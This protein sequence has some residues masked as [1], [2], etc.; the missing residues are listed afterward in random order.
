MTTREQVTIQRQRLQVAGQVQGVGFRPFVYRLAQEVHLPGWVINDS[1]GVT[2]ELQGTAGQLEEF[3]RR[4][5]AELPP[6][7]TISR[8]DVRDVPPEDGVSE[9]IIKPSEGGELADAQ[10]T[11][12]T[13]VCDDCLREMNDPAD[14]RYHSPFINCTNCGPRYTIVRRIPYDRPNTTMA[15]FEMCPLCSREY[16]DPACRRFHAQPIACPVCGPKVW[17]T[18]AR[19]VRVE[20]EDVIAR[21]AELLLDG[22]VLAIKGLG[23]FHLACR[24]DEDHVVRAL[25]RR[26]RRDAKPFAVMVADL[27]HVKDYCA[28]PVQA[29]RLLEGITRPIVLLPM[30][31]PTSI[32]PSVADGLGTLGIML[33]YTPL[34]HLL[35]G[36][37]GMRA[38]P[39]VMTSGNYSD[40]PLVKD[41]DA[42]IAHLGQI[43]DFLLMH[44][45]PIERRV[46][47]SV[48][49]MHIDGSGMLLRRGRGYA[50]KPV[51]LSVTAKPTEPGVTAKPEGATA[52]PSFGAAVQAAKNQSSRPAAVLGVGP[53]LK[54]TVCLYS[55]G[56]A[57]VSEHIG[58]LKDG[59]VYRHFIDT[60]NHL[61]DLFDVE[62]TV[63]AADLH[64]QYLSTQYAMR[65]HRGELEGL[66]GLPIIRVQHHHAHIAAC[67]AEHGR[68]DAV[69]G[70]ACDGVGLGDD[71]AVWGCEVML[72]DLRSYRRLGH[73]RY[74][75]LP[76]G[77]AAAK[78]TAR[79]A[80]AAMW[81]TF[82]PAIIEM[83]VARHLAGGDGPLERAIEMLST[84][85]NCPPS[86]SLGRWFDAVAALS[87]VATTNGFEGQAPMRLEAAIVAGAENAYTFKLIQPPQQGTIVLS[88]GPVL[89]ASEPPFL[90]DLRP[91]VEEIVNELSA[92]YNAGIIAARFHNTVAAF[93]LA[94]AVKA[95]ELTGLRTVALSG[96]C[97]AN[98]YLTHRLGGM[99]AG[100]GFEVL[101]HINMPCNDGCVSLGQAV[102]A[103]N[104]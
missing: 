19:G 26:K 46:D 82:G 101:H 104:Q 22:K 77:D 93:L 8:L 89:K 1:R 40:E 37:P 92:G 7:A 63:L 76:G 99:L 31:E 66:P 50:P 15:G 30:L 2:I 72:A 97:F 90:I 54:N 36:Q 29:E 100:E 24:A 28:V 21:A 96:G 48:V 27:D 81:D 68:T 10:V 70:L 71:N 43:A 74:V 85:I 38:V 67:M 5:H 73:L 53:E 58:D 98:R 56:K 86:S 49:Q 55:G 62:P 13:A 9:F 32:A 39:L 14:P 20:C 69:I 41:N 52:K 44:D 88:T 84:G 78:E 33:P 6:L 95:R 51:E 17:L 64:P 18:D 75:P 25:R 11:V 60:I 61:Q 35:F 42:A 87:A 23:G 94:S 65:R 103:A 45:R 59:R 3:I 4:L 91:M 34:H 16:H 83:P 12:D 79:P 80:L 102:I 47:D 57:V